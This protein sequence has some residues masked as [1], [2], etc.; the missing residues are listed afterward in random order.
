MQVE[1]S[2]LI[3]DWSIPDDGAMHETSSWAVN[4]RN[5]EASH[6]L[7]SAR[8]CEGS[9]PAYA[10]PTIYRD[11]QE[12]HPRQSGVSPYSPAV[13]STFPLKRGSWVTA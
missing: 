7:D 13:P 2:G 5:N 3:H 12:V 4:P 8:L 9:I 6:Y 11:H 1:G 10:G